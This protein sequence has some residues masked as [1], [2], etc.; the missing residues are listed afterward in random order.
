[1]RDPHPASRAR[2][3]RERT[4]KRV[5]VVHQAAR[6]LKRPGEDAVRHQ[7]VTCEELSKASLKCIEDH[8]YTR[9]PA[10]EPFFVAYRECKKE[11]TKA[12]RE[13]NSAF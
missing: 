12:R 5:P 7:D 1:M 4:L 8:G 13:K 9:D 10:C 2:P 11:A 3:H 6:A